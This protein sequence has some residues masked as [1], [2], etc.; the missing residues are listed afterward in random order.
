M[1]SARSAVVAAVAALAIFAAG[2]AAFA[3]DDFD[4][5]AKDAITKALGQ[6]KAAPR[7]TRIA[8]DEGVPLKPL[9]DNK[10]PAPLP[11]TA[12]EVEYDA[13]EGVIEFMSPSSV[14]QLVEFYRSA[15]T[16]LGWSAEMTPI[17]SDTMVA[18]DF[19]KG[20]ARLSFTVVSMGDETQVTAHG[21]A[22][23]AKT[24]AAPPGDQ[25]A[26]P[27]G[28]Q[29]PAAAAAEPELTVEETGGLP[30]PAPHSLSGSESSLFRS[31]ADARTSASLAAVLAFYRRELAKRSWTEHAEK[32]VVKADAAELAYDSPGGPATLKLGRDGDETTVLLSVRDR[33]TAM[34]SPLWP[35]P[36]QV[37]LA[38]G[39]MR[40][41]AAE[42]TVGGK[43]VKV[44]AGAGKNGPDGPT[45]DL[46][47]GKYDLALKSGGHETVDAGPEEIWIVMVG[48][49]GLLA[50]QGY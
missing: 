8:E 45:L 11:S 36:G 31:S 19:V 39:N 47:P 46:A 34:K 18:V 43:K 13:A 1:R 41:K 15:M 25:A 3:E 22:L 38:F 49:G 28:D 40:D 4:A 21:D 10:T 29:A 9:A 44:A 17:N 2:G 12:K 33:A 16:A 5:I 27:S 37:K 48:P 23:A 20:Q 42:I 30:V 7:L 14:K 6:T 24:D 32:A 50:V 35:K 26:A